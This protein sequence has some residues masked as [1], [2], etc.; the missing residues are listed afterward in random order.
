MKLQYILFFVLLLGVSCDKA[1]DSEEVTCFNMERMVVTSNSPVT[2]GDD[3]IINADEV[4]GYRIYN[5]DGP[6]FL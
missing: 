4:G 5:W 3:I 6:Q 1:K 2:I